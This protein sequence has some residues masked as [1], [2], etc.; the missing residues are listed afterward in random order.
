MKL[1][2]TSLANASFIKTKFSK[3]MNM[4]FSNNTK[5]A[6]HI[7]YE[8]IKLSYNRYNDVIQY[9]ENGENIN[10]GNDVNE[11]ISIKK[12]AKNKLQ[13]PPR[14]GLG[15]FPSAILTEIRNTIQTQY[16]YE[17][18]LNDRKIK[19]YI[20]D[21]EHQFN[22]KKLSKMIEKMIMWLSIISEY[23]SN[24]C[25]KELSIYVYLTELKKQLPEKGNVLDLEHVNTAY[26]LSCQPDSE[27]VIYRKEE[28]FKVFMHETF[29]NFGLDFS[30]MDTSNSR[31]YIKQ[32]FR[33]QSEVNLFEAYV[34]FWAELWNILFFVFL[35]NVE[36]RNDFKKYINIVNKLVNYDIIHGILQ[37]KKILSFMDLTYQTII[38]DKNI[39]QYKEN[40]NVLSYYIIKS[41]LYYNV[42]IM[43]DWCRMNNKD[44]ILQFE[45]SLQNQELF[46]E[47]IKENYKTDNYI[48]YL[49]KIE[50]KYKNNSLQMALFDFT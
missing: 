37:T 5:D 47:F 46:C 36:Y 10:N 11:Y 6:I 20:G 35:D 41:I 50:T 48:Q 12:M 44:N 27:I 45:N 34:E 18:I 19:I 1:T 29:H 40:T 16:C 25:A 38:Q 24:K 17:F 31:E 8:N 7:F 9:L 28:W 15:S 22:K 43:I 26:T 30:G 14:F 49:A 21:V 42:N 23:S 39:S 13:F 32:L 2:K 4:M 33:V 3:N